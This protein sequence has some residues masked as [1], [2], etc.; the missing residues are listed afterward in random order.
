MDTTSTAITSSAAAA[1][2]AAAADTVGIHHVGVDGIIK[3]KNKIINIATN[4]E[5]YDDNG[6]NNRAIIL[7]YAAAA[8]KAEID[9]LGKINYI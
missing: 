2:A 3:T 7:P 6:K 5:Y 1:A 9:A 4:D 8:D